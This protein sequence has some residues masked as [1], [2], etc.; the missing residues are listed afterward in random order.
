MM[1]YRPGDE[2][3][4]GAGSGT[5]TTRVSEINVRTDLRWEPAYLKTLPGA[6]KAGVVLVDIICFICIA[7]AAPYY[8]ESALG[9]WVIFVSMT[10]FWVSLALLVMYLIH[11]IEK[12][13]VIPWLMLE[14]G[15]YV[16][17]AFFFF[18]AALASAL[19]AKSSAALG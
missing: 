14:F 3:P 8:K 15:F 4:G 9:E 17:W 2:A 7:L 13:H 5:T 1:D 6:L 12:F 18:T 19:E 16:L 10:G 11:M